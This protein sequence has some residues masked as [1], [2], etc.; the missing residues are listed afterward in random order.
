MSGTARPAEGLARALPPRS[1]HL[2]QLRSGWAKPPCHTFLPDGPGA[3]QTRHLCGQVHRP[4]RQVC[5]TNGRG[6]QGARPPRY[7]QV[8]LPVAPTPVQ[9]G[10]SERPKYRD[11]RRGA[12]SQPFPMPRSAN[13]DS[14]PRLKPV[15]IL[16]S[17]LFCLRV[18]QGV[19]VP[20]SSHPM[21]H[22]SFPR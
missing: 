18:T 20:K 15:R 10:R 9:D 6:G 2:S 4:V 1:P 12:G 5:A 8:P 19:N 11:Q 16:V 7:R 22:A 21:S 17:L 3:R 13:P 14:G